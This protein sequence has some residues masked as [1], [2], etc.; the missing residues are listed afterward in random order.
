MPISPERG[1][2]LWGAAPKPEPKWSGAVRVVVMVLLGLATWGV[3]A[4]VGWLISMAA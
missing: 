3:V 2:P 4:T 1:S